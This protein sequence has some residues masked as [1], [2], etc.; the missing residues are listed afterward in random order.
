MNSIANTVASGSTI[1]A[2]RPAQIGDEMRAVAHEM[3]AG[4]RSAR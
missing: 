2:L 4:R 3:H 1:T